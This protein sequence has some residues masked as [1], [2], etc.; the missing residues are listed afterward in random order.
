MK[1]TLLLIAAFTL[2]VVA[3][4]SQA[5]CYMLLNGECCASKGRPKSIPC[6]TA[7]CWDELDHDDPYDYAVP[8]PPMQFGETDI[9]TGSWSWCKWRSPVCKP[10]NPPHCEWPVMQYES[11]C[12]NTVLDGSTCSGS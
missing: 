2:L 8:A 10:T 12:S 9:D 4:Q 3:I 11:G 6:G 5:A 1:H 7:T